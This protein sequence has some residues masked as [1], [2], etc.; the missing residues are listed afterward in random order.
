MPSLEPI[1]TTTTTEAVTQRLKE[2]ILQG[3]FPPGS[4]LPSVRDLSQ[5][6]SVGQAAIREALAALR[7]MHLV[8][9]RQGE[10][11]FVTRFDADALARQATAIGVLTGQEMQHL[12]ELRRV[13]EGG[14]AHLAALRRR[15][16]DLEALRSALTQMEADIANESLGETADWAFHRAVAAASGNP[17]FPAL[18]DTIAEKVQAQLYQSRKR[19]FERA[20]EAQTL[21]QQHRS[22]AAA[23]ASADGERAERAMQ[24]HLLYVEHQL[25]LDRLESKEG[26]P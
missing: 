1:R 21:L 13:I 22:I 23:I 14:A 2:A 9:I 15:E 24:E 7:A 4:R 5:Q 20:G 3:V 11:T 8:S 25:R 16:T 19:L 18:L 26:S 12:L 6:F 17:L 10:G